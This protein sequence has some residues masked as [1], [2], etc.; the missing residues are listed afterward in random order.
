[1]PELATAPAVKSTAR[2]PWAGPALFIS[3]AVAIL[4]FFWWFLGSASVGH[5]KTGSA[6]DSVAE[7]IRPV[8][9]LLVV[10]SEGQKIPAESITTNSGLQGPN[11]VLPPRGGNTPFGD[12]EVQAAVDYMMAQ[13]Q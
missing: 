9:Q 11:G 10:A 1:V 2:L 4:V 3:V 8:G 13:L 12:A 5:D 6:A 7:R